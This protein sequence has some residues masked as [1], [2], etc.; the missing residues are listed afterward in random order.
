MVE[1]ESLSYKYALLQSAAFVWEG[2]AGT[3][4]P[5]FC[6]RKKEEVDKRS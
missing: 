2:V 3:R 5:G 4:W 6:G 1:D